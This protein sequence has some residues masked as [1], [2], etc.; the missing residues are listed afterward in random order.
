MQSVKTSDLMRRCYAAWEEDDRSAL[1]ELL[2]DDFTFNS[3]ND[4]H[5]NK[6]EYW[7]RCWS[8]SETIR[9]IHILNLLENDDEAFVHYECELKDGTRFRNTEYFRIE[10]NKITAVDVYFG[11]N[12]TSA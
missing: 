2:S 7:E 3:P 5:I 12:V 10:G 8:N 9:A 6:A 11:R 4:D 1:E